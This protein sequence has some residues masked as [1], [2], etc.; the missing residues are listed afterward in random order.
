MRNQS[1]WAAAALF[2]GVLWLPGC[3]QQDSTSIASQRADSAGN[4]AMAKMAS[5]PA[6]PA[7][8]G[9]SKQPTLTAI[10]DSSPDRYL[11]KNATI[12]L[13]TKDAKVASDKLIASVRTAKGYVSD[14]HESTDGV[15]NHSIAIQVR[16][17]AQ[18]FDQSLQQ[19]EVLGKV[20]DSHI[21]AQDVTEEFVDTQ[22][23]LRNLKST[24]ARLLDHL[25]GTGK[26]SE[27]LL[28]E[29][30]LTRVREECE[31]LEGRLKFLGHRVE[32]STFDI[33]LQEAQHPQ[34]ITPPE[35]FSSGKVATDAI[36][37]LVG[38]LQGVWAAVIWIAFWS[39][40][41]LP[42]SLGF[43]F[44]ARRVFHRR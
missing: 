40:V 41:W 5:A 10:A 14:M 32:F 13:E 3:G 28:I 7:S 4:A 8:A 17:P 26:L 42:L 30:E 22:S 6:G 43:W 15:G 35:T 23:R 31:R 9:D 2:F 37:S 1:L 25:R 24:E 19:V 34:A 36:R 21:N 29:K 12:I 44:L 27:T 20:L 38:F 11:I 18:S 16:V 33:T 39:V